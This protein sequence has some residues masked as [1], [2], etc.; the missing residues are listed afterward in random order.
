MGAAT[1]CVLNCRTLPFMK[2]GTGSQLK[3]GSRTENDMKKQSQKQTADF[4]LRYFEC[5]LRRGQNSSDERVEKANPSRIFREG[6]LRYFISF[7][8]CCCGE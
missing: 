5:Q 3:P 6:R 8:C 2:G 4:R 7:T 1:A